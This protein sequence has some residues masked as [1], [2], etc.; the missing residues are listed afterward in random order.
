MLR[1]LN[2]RVFIEIV[3]SLVQCDPEERDGCDDGCNG[4]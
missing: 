4:G 3:F 2:I 1:E